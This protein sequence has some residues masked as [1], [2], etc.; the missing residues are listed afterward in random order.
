MWDPRREGRAI[1]ITLKM[2]H[3]TKK[4]LSTSMYVERDGGRKEKTPAMNEE[5]R[6]EDFGE[7]EPEPW[8]GG[9]AGRE[10]GCESSECRLA[11]RSCLPQSEK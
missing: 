10:N 7:D 4:A 1:E 6:M 3:E 9:G 11:R 5:V 8:W 2:L